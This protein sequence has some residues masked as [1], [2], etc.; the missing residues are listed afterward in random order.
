[1]NFGNIPTQNHVNTKHKCAKTIQKKVIVIITIN[2]NLHMDFINS[3]SIHNKLTKC[4]EKAIDP[5][6]VKTSG[7]LDNVCMD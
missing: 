1:M 7:P 3:P 6:D 2:A 5:E 4:H